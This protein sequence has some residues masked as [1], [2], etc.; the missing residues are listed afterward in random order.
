MADAAIV[1]RPLPEGAL[2]NRYDVPGGYVDCFTCD[3]ARSVDLP[4]LIGAFY[5]SRAFRP[6]RWLLG[7][8]LGKKADNEDVARLARGEAEQFSAWSVEARSADQIMLCDFQGKTRSWLMVM[9]IEQGTRLHFGSAVVPARSRTDRIA[10]A[11][12]TGFH[13]WYSRTLLRSAL[14]GL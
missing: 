11:A 5:Q 6:E 3:V 7:A 1:A 2:L 8:V 10:F 9:P 14:R 13:R 4:Q 12:L